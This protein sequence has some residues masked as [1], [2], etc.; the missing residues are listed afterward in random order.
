MKKFLLFG[1]LCLFAGKM[2]A[3]NNPLKVETYQLKNG[4]TIY[5]NEDHTMPMV[6]GMIIVKGGA[7]R[8]P[9]Y[10][11]GIAHYFEHIMFKGT[12]KIGTINYTGEKPY[13]DSIRVLYD[14]LGK[15]KDEKQRLEI[16]KEINR[17]SVKA[18][19]YAI[20]NEFNKILTDMGGKAINAS[21]SHEWINYYNSFPSN[22][23]EKWIEVYSERF[24]HPVF[25]LFQSELETVYEEKNMYEDNPMR[26]IFEKF[27][28]QFYK[29][30]PYGQQTVLGTTEHLKNPSLSKMEEYFNT[31]YVAKNMALILSG[32]FDPVKIKPLI[33]EKFGIWRSGEVPI[34]LAVNE[35]PFKGREVFKKRMTPIKVGVR[36]YRTIPKNHPDEIAFNVCANLLSNSS[37]TGLM[38]KLAADNKL[39]FAGLQ[40]DNFTE[41]GGSY[42]FFVPKIV[43]QSLKSAEKLTIKQF[44]RLRNGDF[45]DELLAAVKIEMKKQHERRL[46][47]MRNRT[48]LI[49]DA[50]VY[51]ANWDDFLA[52]PSKIDKVS[53]ADIMKIANTYF[54]DNYLDFYSKMG[55]PKKDKIKKPP[56]KPIQPKNSDQKSD[57][58]KKIAQMPIVEMTPKFIDFGKDV[59]CTQVNKGINVFTTPNPI[60]NIFSI[61][62]VYGKGD[63]NDPMVD[64]AAM[65]FD[66]S[67]P[68]GMKY[69]DFK[70]KLQLLGCNLSGYADLNSCTINISGLDENLEASLKLINQYLKNISIE[71]KMLKP[72][73]QN[74]KMELK[75]ENKD[76]SSKGNALAEYA[77]YGNASKFLTRLSQKEIKGLKI[78]QLVDKMNEIIGYEYEVHYC[79]TKSAEDFTEIFKK[80]IE[81]GT[82]L[83]PKTNVIERKRDVVSQNTIY[84]VDDKKALQSH[85]YFMVEGGVNDEQSLVKLDAFN[86]YTGGSMSSIIF[87]EIREFRSLAY[88]SNGWYNASF[89]RDKPGY[90]KGWLSTQADK[91]NEAV[92]VYSGLLTSLPQ[93]PERIDAVRKNLT[94]SINANQSSPRYKSRSVSR[95]MAQ[96][97][98]DDPRKTRYDKYLNVSFDDILD[99]YNTNLKGKP[100]LITIVG[101]KKRI[102]LEKLK[103]FGTLKIIDKSEIFKK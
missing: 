70:R 20:P 90:F 94:L 101:D 38:D 92:E 57:Y 15:T 82:N 17:I 10:A 7:K 81:T 48:Y 31:Y 66:N 5:L 36:G 3:Q 42:V 2:P 84:F 86:D 80:C 49:A 52:I 98:T 46:E 43:G 77:Q 103:K 27:Y 73:A 23:I 72:L 47:D 16:Q 74:N 58:A 21:T 60:N 95:W 76:V 64:Q 75:F 22:Q 93:K 11:T 87:Q 50:F 53:K 55:F 85:I 1:F 100:I 59:V 25:R 51:G 29:N 33:E 62:L 56:F 19:D 68:A 102:D 44:D 28:A 37:S 6:H 30:S 9:K 34:D 79:G 26:L 78:K 14:N 71:E 35:A 61:S 69:E 32:D 12:D 89:Y 4:L 63:F 45:D 83:K 18:A 97:Y 96:G 65:M 24:I 54:A 41:T 13:L 39:L 91:T 99:F 88:G 8:D 67:N 40:N